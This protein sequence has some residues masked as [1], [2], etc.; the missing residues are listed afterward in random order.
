MLL[1]SRVAGVET[2]DIGRRLREI[3]LRFDQARLKIDDVVAELV[4]LGLNGFIVFVQNGVVADLLFE[5]LDVAFF[6]LAECSL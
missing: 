6:A 2:I 1:L 4:V 5:F 3:S